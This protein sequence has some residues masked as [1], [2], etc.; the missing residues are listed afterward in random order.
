[1]SSNYPNGFVNGVTIRGVPLQQAHPGEV[2]WVN[3]SGVALANTYGASDNNRGT[4]N[5]PFSTLDYA[6][7]KCT[8]SRGDVIFVMPGHAETI[9]TDGGVTLDKAGVAV[10]GLGVGSLRPTFTMSVVASAVVI[11]A[12]NVSISNLKFVTGVDVSTNCIDITAAN[13]AIENCHFSESAGDM[14]WLDVISATGGTDNDC[15]GLRV[16]DCVYTSIDDSANNFIAL[17]SDVDEMFIADN[18]VC[19]THANALKLIDVATGKTM[20]N[21]QIHRN[22][23]DQR[24]R[25]DTSGEGSVI[26]GSTATDNSGVMT[27]NLI[28][29]IDEAGQVIEDATGINKHENYV[30]GAITV[31]G[32]LYPAAETVD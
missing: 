29:N 19:M 27:H 14:C 10:V 23:L 24:A 30:T 3:N 11:S 32:V 13:A 26:G 18:F 15:D 31:Q 2:F 8:A 16:T 1:M 4:F 21:M 5:A 9:A 7:G 20:T 28:S 25:T 6:I 22:I 12:A 17:T